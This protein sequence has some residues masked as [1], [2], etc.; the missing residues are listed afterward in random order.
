MCPAAHWVPKK[1]IKVRPSFEVPTVIE[2]LPKVLH[3]SELYYPPFEDSEATAGS[4]QSHH[5]KLAASGT[6]QGSKTRRP[7]TSPTKGSPVQPER[8]NGG[9]REGSRPSSRPSTRP[10]AAHPPV[11][12]PH[13]PAH[14]K[15]ITFRS[16]SGKIRSGEVAV[17]AQQAHHKLTDLL[18]AQ[19]HLYAAEVEAAAF[20]FNHTPLIDR[21]FTPESRPGGATGNAQSTKGEFSPRE[22]GPLD[23]S[24]SGTG[25]SP[26]QIKELKEE[27][28]AAAEEEEYGGDC[29]FEPDESSVKEVVKSAPAPAPLATAE[30]MTE[31][32]SS[33]ASMVSHKSSKSATTPKPPNTSPSTKRAPP[34]SSPNASMKVE[35]K[36]EPPVESPSAKIRTQESYFSVLAIANQANANAKKSSTSGSGSGGP[37]TTSIDLTDLEVESE[38]KKQKLESEVR[39]FSIA[40]VS[41]PSAFEPCLSYLTELY[42]GF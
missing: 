4:P 12:H 7:A 6:V 26:Q 21:V 16:P 29:G 23:L 10:Q 2:P 22:D 15:E 41:E 28:A 34:P 24:L 19:Y 31:R 27:D 35:A 42:V 36:A 40:F 33:P 13:G 8:S 11:S 3:Y 37:N 1:V 38:E 30:V 32:S 39:H 9:S 20:Q 14:A 17:L 18:D 25:L 5:S